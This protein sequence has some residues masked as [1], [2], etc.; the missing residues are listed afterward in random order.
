VPST[1][2]VVLH[3]KQARREGKAIEGEK[4]VPLHC[5]WTHSLLQAPKKEKKEETEE[6][7]AFKEKKKQEQ[8]QL[9]DARDKGAVDGNL[10]SMH[11][12]DGPCSLEG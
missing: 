11:S 5:A 12:T 6:E 3:V 2:E 7:K 1:S 8:S 10:T 9:K 4:R